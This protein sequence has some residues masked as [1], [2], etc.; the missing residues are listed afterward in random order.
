M[1]LISPNFAA[2]LAAVRWSSE[3]ATLEPSP[4]KLL[5]RP[6]HEFT[7]EPASVVNCRLVSRFARP[8]LVSRFRSI[9]WTPYLIP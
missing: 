5:C 6:W 4:R 3:T 7:P 2:C 9:D 8:T 1:K